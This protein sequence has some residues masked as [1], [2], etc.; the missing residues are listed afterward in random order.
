MVVSDSTPAPVSGIT[1]EMI[2]QGAAAIDD[3][4]TMLGV[5]RGEW[6]E[7]GGP[8]TAE[9]L[10]A[11]VLRG[12]LSGL[13]VVQPPQAD[14][15]SLHQTV[16]IVSEANRGRDVVLHLSGPWASKDCVQDMYRWY[17]PEE[18][19][20]HAGRLLAAAGEARRMSTESS[21]QHD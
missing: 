3:L 17:A 16:W 14:H 10:A 2:E 11:A 5:E 7:P 4:L 20:A 6:N 8:T 9:V 15:T 19:E 13:V 1:E 21:D 12:G 18:A